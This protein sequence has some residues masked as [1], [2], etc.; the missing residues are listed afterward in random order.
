MDVALLSRLV[1]IYLFIIQLVLTLTDPD[2][3][4]TFRESPIQLVKLLNLY[5]LFRFHFYVLKYELSE[6]N[7]KQRKMQKFI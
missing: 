1:F 3:Q 4:K 5:I 7:I 2:R 6:A